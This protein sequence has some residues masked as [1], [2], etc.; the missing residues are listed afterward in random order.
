MNPRAEIHG[1]VA[2]GF[3]RVR[4]AFAGN[5]EEGTSCTEVGAGFAVTRR[6]EM[7]V[8]LWG[9][10]MD[11]ARTRSWQHDTIVNTYSTTKG[12]AAICIAV[13][14]SRGAIDRRME[15]AFTRFVVSAKGLEEIGQHLIG[16]FEQRL[17]VADP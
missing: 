4:E 3:E 12:I 17:L 10:F 1:H 5:F 15:S 13:L 7:V 16:R 8:D 11:A 2:P 9:G 14:E 6:G